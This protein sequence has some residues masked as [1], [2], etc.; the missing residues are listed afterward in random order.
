[1]QWLGLGLDTRTPRTARTAR[2]PSTPRVAALFLGLS[3]LVSA[4]SAFAQGADKPPP[5]APGAL[6]EAR[7]LSDAFVSVAER[8][9][10]SVVQI[11]VTARDE[12][13]DQITRFFG[14]NQD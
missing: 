9:S 6:A 12:S 8:V 7:K 14:K 2:T 4:P 13:A 11:D 10:P 5:A 3:L 1:M